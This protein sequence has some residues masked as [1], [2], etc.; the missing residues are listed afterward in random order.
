MKHVA[1]LAS[2]AFLIG[3]ADD[4]FNAVET[5]HME[6]TKQKTAAPSI[7]S[8]PMAT[9]F[10]AGD[11]ATLAIPEMKCPFGCFPKAEDALANIDGVA[12]VELVEQ[13]Q[14]GVINARRVVVTFDG[15]VDGHAAIVA[16][17]SVDLPGSSFE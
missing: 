5:Q 11:S 12:G 9:S 17:D 14:E 3:C 13:E 8:L 7:D 6:Q 16:L 2:T 4:A 15:K 10:N 1:L